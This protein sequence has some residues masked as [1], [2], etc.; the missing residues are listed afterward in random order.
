MKKLGVVLCIVI[1]LSGCGTIMRG[2]SHNNYYRGIEANTKMV[3]EPYIWLLS[4]GVIPIISIISMPIDIAVD[5]LLLPV[6]FLIKRKKDKEIDRSDEQ[7]RKEN[8]REAKETEVLKQPSEKE[9]KP[10]VKRW[11]SQS[12]AE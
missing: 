4:L 1:F 12:I 5:T 6:D 7:K 11:F 2:N 3:N 10:P 9:N 8:E